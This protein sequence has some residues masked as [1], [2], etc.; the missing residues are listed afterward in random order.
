MVSTPLSSHRSQVA[1]S[2]SLKTRCHSTSPLDRSAPSEEQANTGSDN[3]HVVDS[4]NP[5]K[6]QCP[7]D[8]S[9][10]LH[11]TSQPL[12]EGRGIGSATSEFL[13]PAEFWDNLSTV[14]L[15]R[16]ALRELDRRNAQST[17]R[18]PSASYHPPVTRR[19]PARSTK[20][21]QAL[22]PASKFLCSCDPK[23]LKDVRVFSRQGGPDLSD[24]RGACI[25]HNI[26]KYQS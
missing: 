23:C 16:S 15:T 12:S 9:S 26:Y 1:S 24:L 5:R 7:G 3:R 6:R 22:Q 19:A 13:P 8:Q 10:Q 21:H 25:V 17:I 4:L 14:W 18:L 11:Q 20:T 2:H